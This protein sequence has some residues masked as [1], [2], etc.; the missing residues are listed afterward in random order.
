MN[1]Q[2]L[3]M[4]G[5]PMI[6]GSEI[7][8]SS[9]LVYNPSMDGVSK[10]KNQIVQ[11]TSNLGFCLALLQTVALILLYEQRSLAILSNW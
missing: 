8:S 6:N 1:S 5:Y 10:G 9:S 7:N 2:E 3:G 4:S 11:T